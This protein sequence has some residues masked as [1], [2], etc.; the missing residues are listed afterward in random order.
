MRPE[1]VT[2]VAEF[3]GI[4]EEE[5]LERHHNYLQHQLTRWRRLEPADAAGLAEYYN[6]NLYLYE[7]IAAPSFGLVRLVHPFL[8][9]ASAILDYGSG[10][11]THG[12]HFL[13]Q[14]HQLSFVDVP[15][16]HFDFVRWS[17]ERAGL[18]ADFVDRSRAEALPSGAF[19]AIICFD[20]LE[21]VSDWREAVAL[22]ARL[23]KPEGKLFLVVSFREFEDH[24]I[25]IASRTGLTEE[26]LRVCMAKHGFH[27]VFCR[28]RPVPLTH[29]LE[30]FK[31]FARRPDLRIVRLGKVFPTGEDFLRRGALDEAERCFAEL[32]AWNPED[33]AAHRELAR[34][35]LLRGDLDEAAARVARAIELLPDDV[36][37]WELAGEVSLSAGDSLGAARKFALAATHW[38]EFAA[39]AHAQLVPLI[40]D[41][42]LFAGIWAQLES[43]R[44]RQILLAF[45]IGC[46]AYVRA[47][48]VALHLTATHTRSSYAGYLVWKEY[49]RLLRELGRI[50]EAIEVLRRLLTLHPD[51]PWLH[52]D[53]SLCHSA[54]GDHAAALAELD[55]EEA[56]TSS[57]AVVMFE[58]GQICRR[59]GDLMRAAVLF[60]EAA[61]AMPEFSA[62]LLEHG[63]TLIALDET[64][65]ALA[66]FEKYMALTPEDA[67]TLFAL[68]KLRQRLGDL[69]GAIADLKQIVRLRPG[70]AEAWFTL[71]QA[72]MVVAQR[73]AAVRAF[74]QAYRLAPNEMWP[75][76]D[77][78]LKLVLATLELPARIGF[79]P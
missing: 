59:Q 56:N 11:G 21:H 20:V 62:A 70:D 14:G 22:F 52:F 15:S 30:P 40:N 79:K 28:D 49:A 60:A 41:D 58:K 24:V 72:E 35:S 61:E 68:A 46:G 67:E 9:P 29:P 27:E 48:E 17:V 45:L 66:A 74:N 65:G 36:S 25:H 18:V 2:A 42:V 44:E 69:A 26:A 77:F 43:W 4:A 54:Q 39:Q 38:P 47:Q 6:D 16:P 37:A 75:R 7:L 19:D 55:M 33:F 34:T 63:R 1:T 13:H 8:A 5:L 73:V 32:V 23:L 50:P 31:V 57:H 51:R 71:G 10:I 3:L 53:L 64:A 76:Y 12:L 78:W